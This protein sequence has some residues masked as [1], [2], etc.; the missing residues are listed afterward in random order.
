MELGARR[1]PFFTL[2]GL[3]IAVLATIAA[4]FLAR[5]QSRSGEWAE[6]SLRIQVQLASLTDHVRAIESAHRG[7]VLSRSPAMK[8][9]LEQRIE[10]FHPLFDKL[11][12]EIRD[13]PQQV[14]SAISL[15]R[16]VL[17]KV[18]FAREGIAAS[19]RGE[20]TEEIARIESGEGARRM[21]VAIS[22]INRMMSEEEA[23]FAERQSRTDILVLGLG[24]ALV[25]TV[26]LVLVVAAVVI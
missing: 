20:R 26:L 3:L 9:D 14:A 12:H 1:I 18:R 13:N 8:A 7:Y 4:L 6:H 23:L 15:R 10:L 21:Q 16:A 2:A 19:D 5:A 24:F 25:A 22:I 17:Q 11:R